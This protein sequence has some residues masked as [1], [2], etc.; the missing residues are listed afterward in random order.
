MRQKEDKVVNLGMNFQRILDAGL[1]KQDQEGNVDTV[2]IWD[3][4]Q[5]ILRQKEADV[6]SASTIQM[7]NQH[8]SAYVPA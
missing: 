5:S 4:H 1:L 2:K 6:L 8:Q 7:Q 3:E